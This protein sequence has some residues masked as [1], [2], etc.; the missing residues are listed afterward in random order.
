MPLHFLVCPFE[1]STVASQLNEDQ[2]CLP[3][4]TALTHGNC[5]SSQPAIATLCT[6]E[7]HWATIRKSRVD[8]MRE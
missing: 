4:E 2:T 3:P 5:M 1:K 7:A 6:S 8:M